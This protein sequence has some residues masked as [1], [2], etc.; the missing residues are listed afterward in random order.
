MLGERTDIIYPCRLHLLAVIQRNTADTGLVRHVRHVDRISE[1]D[2]EPRLDTAFQKIIDDRVEPFE[3]VDP[4]F[5]FSLYPA[6]LAA[7]EFD[8][9]SLE[10][11]VAFFGLEQLSVEAFF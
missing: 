11:I 9:G 3:G 4:L 5:L 1:A 7:C 10:R 6:G 2:A 8:T